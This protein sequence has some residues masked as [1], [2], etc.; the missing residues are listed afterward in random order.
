MLQECELRSLP[1]AAQN[2]RSR[3]GSITKQ[4]TV[5]GWGTPCQQSVTHTLCV[6]KSETLCGFSLQASRLEEFG[7]HDIGI[8]IRG[9]ATILKVTAL[10][11]LCRTWNAHGCSSVRNSITEFVDRCGLMRTSEAPFISD[12][13]DTDMLKML[14]GQ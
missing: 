11:G 9:W 1:T 2:K 12:P 13:I 4:I 8:H 7:C 10:I 14:G 3:R 6:P 5:L